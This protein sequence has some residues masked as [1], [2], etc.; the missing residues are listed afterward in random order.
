VKILAWIALAV[1]IT[2]VAGSVE[3]SSVKKRLERQTDEIDA[4]WVNVD[5]ALS[6]RAG[7]MPDF[8]ET[9]KRTVGDHAAGAAE[10]ADSRASLAAGRTPQEKIRAY[11]R[12]DGAFS[13]LLA[14]TENYPRLRSDKDF[15]RRLDGIA[16]TENRIA[17]ERQKYNE[18]LENYNASIQV[19]PNNLVAA[20][21]EFVR[22]DE[23]FRPS[24][25]RN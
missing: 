10:I 5:Q 4:Q 9:V 22:R 17:V 18:A 1:F 25:P 13:R 14:L 21:S 6:E 11:G 7:L 2:A 3:Y 20:M 16:V 8:V 23:Y 24:L 12:L 19:F 15:Q